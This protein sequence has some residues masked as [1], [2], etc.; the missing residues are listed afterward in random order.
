MYVIV[1]A[2]LPSFEPFGPLF[3]ILLGSRS[4]NMMLCVGSRVFLLKVGP[5]QVLGS[6]KL[7]AGA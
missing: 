5:A 1:V 7:A 2:G 4:R 6:T 3:E